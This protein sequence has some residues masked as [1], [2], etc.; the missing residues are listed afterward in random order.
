[1]PDLELDG[2]CLC[3]AVRYCCTGELRG[4]YHCH[5]SRCRKATGTGHATNLMLVRA[6]L[7]WL[8]GGTLVGSYKVPEA[9]RF[10][11]NFCTRCGGPLPRIIEA[12][13]AVVI[14]AG[15]L[16]SELAIAPRA[17]IFLD[18]RASWSCDDSPLPGFARYAE[19]GG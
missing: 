15:S 7:H 2:S 18:S 13:E 11:N 6:E 17:R 14:P 8:E 4:F 12:L 9:R 1:M 3:G 19:E 16:D 5:C 10:R